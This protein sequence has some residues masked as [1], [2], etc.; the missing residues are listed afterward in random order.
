MATKDGERF[1]RDQVM[2]ILPQLSAADEIIIADDHST[3]RTLDIIHTI[4]DPRIRVI[5]TQAPGIVATFETTL[6]AARGTYILLSDQDDVWKESKVAVMMTHL[7]GFDLVV[8]DCTLVDEYLN[9]I[10]PSYRARHGSRRGLLRNLLRNSYI[11]CC[12]G[13]H[14]SVLEKA[15]PFPPRLPMHDG[16][17]G[18]VAELYFTVGFIEDSLVLYRRHAGSYTAQ[19]SAELTVAQRLAHRLNLLRAL[20]TLTTSRRSA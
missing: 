20:F 13:F 8:S 15:L 2:S 14:R 5:R 7:R 12:M 18:L 19:S 17:L 4:G 6:R 3:D 16:W 9:I 11:G 1:V 10:K